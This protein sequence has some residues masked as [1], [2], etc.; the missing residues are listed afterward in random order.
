M[1]KII[2]I[3]SL[4]PDEEDG[5]GVYSFMI[6]PK[7]MPI[8]IGDL[9]GMYA[10]KNLGLKIFVQDRK[11]LEKFR[12]GIEGGSNKFTDCIQIQA[13]AALYNLA[14]K[15][16]DVVEIPFRGEDKYAIVTDYLAGSEATEDDRSYVLDALK[17]TLRIYGAE[18]IAIDPNLNNIIGRK[19]VDFQVF[20]FFNKEK[21]RQRVIERAKTVT[22]WGSKTG[23]SYEDI[24]ELEVEGQRNTQHRI[25]VLGMDKV[26]FEGKTVLDIGCSTGSFCRYA[27]RRG[28]KR[29]IG[30]DIGDVPQVAAEISIYLGDFNIDYY[31]FR[32]N[33][34]D[35]NDYNRLAELTGLEAFD[36]VFFL[37]VH[38]QIGY[39][40][41]YMGKLCKEM[42]FVEGHSADKEETYRPMMEKNFVTRFVGRMRNNARP[43][44]VG[45]KK[46]VGIK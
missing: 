46:I 12:W 38:Q 44:L 24:E 34:D 39:P 16:Y 13:L 1:K 41:S 18:R 20:K 35:P 28:A 22:D 19:Y 26:D 42:I 8:Y 17:Q 32:F 23:I 15:V 10:R 33:K 2:P 45:Y 6:S 21:F 11:P 30:V 40:T 14:P 27:A 3:K 36:Y 31:H 4:V 9:D 7:R 25:E 37:S 5:M 29:V 43:A